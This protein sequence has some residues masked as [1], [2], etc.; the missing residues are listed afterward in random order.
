MIKIIHVGETK[1]KG[2]KHYQ[3]TDHLINGKHESRT[4][5]QCSMLKKQ[6]EQMTDRVMTYIYRAII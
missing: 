3:E 1:K 5:Q 2:E 6:Q 4:M